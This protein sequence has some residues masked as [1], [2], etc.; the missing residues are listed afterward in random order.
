MANVCERW[1]LI[2][3]LR[4]FAAEGR[5]IWG[6]CAGMIFLASGAEGAKTGGQVLLGG[7]PVTVSRNFFGAAINSFEVRNI[8]DITD[9]HP[10]FVTH[11]LQ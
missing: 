1:G 2:D 9:P 8:W 11:L 7:L 5:P 4:A 3:A 6:T 10:L